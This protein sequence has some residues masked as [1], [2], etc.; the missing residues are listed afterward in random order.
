MNWAAP[1]SAW[2]LLLA[3]PAG[4]L[5]RRAVVQRHHGLRLVAGD[6]AL[7]LARSLRVRQLLAF[8]LP[9]VAALL[10]I[11]ALCRPQWG[12]VTLQQPTRALDI[13]VALDVSRSMLADDLPPT[14]LAAAKNAVAGLL[15]QLRGDRIGLIAFAGSA[16]LVCPLTQDY[17]TFAAV[18]AE[19]GS[20]SIP[21]GGTSLA[22]ALHEALR[23]FGSKDERG[24]FLILIS[25]GEDHGRDWAAAIEA[26]RR[27]GV[28]IYSV[29][30][31]TLA[32]GLIPLPGGEFL[33]NRQG[34]IVRSRLQTVP[35]Q[36]LAS[37]TGG[38]LLDLAHDPQALGKLYATEL[39]ARER[40]DI[41]RTR[42]QPV[43]RFQFPLALA[44]LLLL[45][46]PC[47]GRRGKS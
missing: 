7:P 4:F 47:F 25:D 5:V 27:S 42:Q 23:A 34:A 17:S 29:A 9:A 33:K 43:E 15:P 11:L 22:G 32:G 35:L 21:L 45:I 44:L 16:F 19:T 24:K 39:S 46:E 26:L 14:R 8:L 28:T 13:L 30:A 40:R 36:A 18:L 12:Y 38:R 2:L 3:V 10:V 41:R 20:D 6:A 31:G 1:E 37:K